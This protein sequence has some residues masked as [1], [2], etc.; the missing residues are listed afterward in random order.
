M[1]KSVSLGLGTRWT[2]GAAVSRATTGSAGRPLPSET[3]EGASGVSV[4]G[5]TMML[6]CRAIRACASAA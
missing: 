5:V 3:G 2:P 6:F 1:R 4:E